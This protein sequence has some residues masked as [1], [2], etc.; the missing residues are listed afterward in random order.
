MEKYAKAT[1]NNQIYFLGVYGE[2]LDIP[3]IDQMKISEIK[4]YPIEIIDST[5]C[6]IKSREHQHFKQVAFNYAKEFNA[7]MLANL[8]KNSN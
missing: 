5:G 6:L 1:K 4:K 2:G 3:G 7:K 8:E